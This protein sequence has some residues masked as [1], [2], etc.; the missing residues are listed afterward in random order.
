MSR[1]SPAPVTLVTV[2]QFLA[3]PVLDGKAELVRGELCPVAEIF[4]GI[5]RE[6]Q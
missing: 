4:E 2:E 1:P 6:P 5:A 3:F